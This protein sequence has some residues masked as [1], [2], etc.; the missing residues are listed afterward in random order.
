MSYVERVNRFQEM[1]GM[2]EKRYTLRE[3]GKRFDVTRERARQILAK[4]L[5]GIK[6]PKPRLYPSY[7]DK[8]GGRERNREIVRIRDK[9][10]CQDCGNVWQEGK[11]RFD[12]HHLNGLCGK[13]S[14]LYD[15][16]DSLDG[17]IT[18]CHK[19]HFNR[20]EH[21]VQSKEF[22]RSVS[23]GSFNTKKTHCIRGHEF[24]EDNTSIVRG[25]RACK[26]CAKIYIQNNKTKG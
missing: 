9:F 6:P 8:M 4:G 26:A 16:M 2:H 12:I 10:T 24:T 18:L 22:A 15:K 11:R 3:I 21:K 13:K 20:P 5:Q 7:V 25:G 17:L 14:R 19:C 23:E 1:R